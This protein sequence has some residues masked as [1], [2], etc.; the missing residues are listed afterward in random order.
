MGLYTPM[1]TMG[2]VG[3]KCSIVCTSRCQHK[4]SFVASS[5]LVEAK[6]EE[7]YDNVTIKVVGLERVFSEEVVAVVK[8]HST[9]VKNV[10]FLLIMN[11]KKWSFQLLDLGWQHPSTKTDIVM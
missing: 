6:T 3:F 5:N 7:W 2:L 1:R 9:F 4:S 10:A 8:S 11:I